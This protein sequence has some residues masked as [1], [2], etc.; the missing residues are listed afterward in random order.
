MTK[1]EYER[2]KKD[3]L[4][5]FRNRYKSN[6]GSRKE[7]KRSVYDNPNLTEQQKDNFWGLVVFKVEV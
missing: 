7:L 4:Q 5:F 6:K 1:E 3:N 2:F